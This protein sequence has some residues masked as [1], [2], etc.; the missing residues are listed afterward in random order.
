[1]NKLKTLKIFFSYLGLFC[2]LFCALGGLLTIKWKFFIYF[3][4]WCLLIHAITLLKILVLKQEKTE[5]TRKLLILSW[6]IGWSVTIG[7]WFFIFPIIDKDKLPPVWHYLL[8]HGGIH[9]SIVLIFCKHPI[10]I[11][12]KDLCIPLF[13]LAVYAFFLLLPLKIFFG[14]AVY[15]MLADSLVGGLIVIV[16][17][18]FIVSFSFFVGYFMIKNKKKLG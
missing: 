10:T 3:T 12:P 13:V 4:N 18:F 11:K 17:T 15:P 5:W 16:G 6:S 2:S 1:M 14:L 7:F 8:C 9:A